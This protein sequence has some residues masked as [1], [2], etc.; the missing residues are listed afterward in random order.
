[1]CSQKG[2][3]LLR[4]CAFCPPSMNVADFRP[5]R[6]LRL[7]YWHV[8]ES[9][10]ASAPAA[11]AWGRVPG[12]QPQGHAFVTAF[13]LSVNTCTS[14]ILLPSHTR[15]WLLIKTVWE[16]AFELNSFTSTHT[17]RNMP[18]SPNKR[19][20]RN[21]GGGTHKR[22]RSASHTREQC[23][24]AA[25]PDRKVSPFPPTSH[26]PLPHASEGRAGARSR[27][28]QQAG[29]KP[30]WQL[31]FRRSQKPGD[32]PCGVPSAPASH[33]CHILSSKW[34]SRRW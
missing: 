1:M 6:H 27:C 19:E 3:F 15:T 26:A 9:K 22:G 29:G 20:A 23:S 7:F 24:G 12:H 2:C 30:R 21:Q 13:P 16:M 4:T 10:G 8:S 18:N 5:R 28:P 34:F 14:F 25:G 11:G 17:P 31:R 33:S 32:T